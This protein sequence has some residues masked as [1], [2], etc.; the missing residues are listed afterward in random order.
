MNMNVIFPMRLIVDDLSDM[1]AHTS[2]DMGDSD[3]WP[4]VKTEKNWYV[5][6]LANQIGASYSC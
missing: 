3:C 2:N 6:T 4:A 5:N 1:Y